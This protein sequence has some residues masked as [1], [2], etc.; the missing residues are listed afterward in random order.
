MDYW[1]RSVGI[2]ISY[3][4]NWEK[5]QRDLHIN[6]IDRYQWRRRVPKQGHDKI[7]WISK[8][9]IFPIEGQA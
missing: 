2:E 5:D 3:V 1:W 4:R 6:V 9:Q 8:G 7:G